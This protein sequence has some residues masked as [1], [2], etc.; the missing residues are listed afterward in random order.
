MHGERDAAV[1][2]VPAGL[3]RE[4]LA[5]LVAAAGPATL[6]LPR[7]LREALRAAL[8]R[9]PVR[10]GR[11]SAAGRRRASTGSAPRRWPSARSSA[12]SFSP[13]GSRVCT[14]NRGRGSRGPARTGGGDGG[15]GRRGHA[16]GRR[17]RP[18]RGAPR[19][20]APR[21]HG[22]TPRGDG[23][24][25]HPPEAR[26]VARRVLVDR[27]ESNS[28]ADMPALKRPSRPRSCGPPRRG[29][30]G[31][32]GRRRR[33]RPAARSAEGAAPGPASPVRAGARSTPTELKVN[34]RAGS[35]AYTPSLRRPRNCSAP[36]RRA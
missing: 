27:L 21:R 20:T 4:A 7:D 14:C 32:S 26:D 2:V 17:E 33:P 6:E 1:T 35:G 25:E 23:A 34:L 24:P 18:R 8:P 29:P 22:G 13:S 36:P 19:A 12:G 11:S 10:R 28:L 30:P 16:R 5:L 3:Q 31:P 9:A 15:A